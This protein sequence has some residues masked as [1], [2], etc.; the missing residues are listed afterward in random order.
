MKGLLALGFCVIVFGVN[1]QSEID[2][3]IV[4]NWSVVE[5]RKLIFSP[6]PDAHPSKTELL[7]NIFKSMTFEFRDDHYFK[8]KAAYAELTINDG[9]WEVTGNNI[10]IDSWEAH[11]RSTT[12]LRIQVKQQGSRWIFTLDQLAEL[13]VRKD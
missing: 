5:V 11:G 2:K 9:Y 3:Q 4:G 6:G 1:A 12:V 8:S 13:E 7:R 10:A